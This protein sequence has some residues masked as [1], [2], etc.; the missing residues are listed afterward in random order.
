MASIKIILTLDNGNARTVEH[1]VPVKC[2]KHADCPSP[3]HSLFEEL[4]ETAWEATQEGAQMALF[5]VGKFDA[6]SK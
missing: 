6:E 5:N 3:A 4:K 1:E 2:A